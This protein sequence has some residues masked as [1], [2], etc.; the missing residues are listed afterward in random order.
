VCVTDAVSLS[1]AAGVWLAS[2]LLE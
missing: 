2:G 1:V